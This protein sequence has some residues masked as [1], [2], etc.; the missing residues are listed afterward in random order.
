MDIES[1]SQCITYLQNSA[2]ARNAIEKALPIV[3]TLAGT[4]LGFILNFSWTLHKESRSNKNKLMCMDED[5]HRINHFLLEM[6][7]QYAEH[8]KKVVIRDYPTSHNLP[9]EI[10]SSCIEEYFTEVAH[11]YTKNQ[12]YWLQELSSQLKYINTN[13]SDIRTREEIDPYNLSKKFL[14]GISSALFCSKLCVMIMK[15]ETLPDIPL[16]K[17]LELLGISPVAVQAYVVARANADNKN[18]H[19]HL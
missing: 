14:D 4:F 16:E 8:L 5:T 2:P 12:R 19:L 17:Q 1:F 13:L 3:G 9:S 7:K 18:S 6:T 10:H 11:K 15:N